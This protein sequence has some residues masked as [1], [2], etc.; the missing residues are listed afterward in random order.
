MEATDLLQKLKSAEAKIAK[1]EAALELIR[2]EGHEHG[3]PWAQKTARL[4]LRKAS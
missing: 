2:D 1:L 4:A 3:M